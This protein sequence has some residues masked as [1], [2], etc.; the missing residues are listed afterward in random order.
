MKRPSYGVS[1][2]STLV[3]KLTRSASSKRGFYQQQLL[4]RWPLIVG[5]DV[6][7]YCHP[8]KISHDPHGTY[9][10]TLHLR[11][12]PAWAPHVTYM[13]P[14]I[15][16]K[17]ASFLGYRAV[18]RIVI[19]Q[20]PV[21]PAASTAVPLAPAKMRTAPASREAAHALNSI[22]DAEL[23]QRLAA[24]APT[25]TDSAPDAVSQN[26]DSLESDL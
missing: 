16:D 19:H 15:L 26:T 20:A 9:G 14:V 1:A 24:F 12:E 17:I 23:A 10:A 5:R 8:Q 18:S 13:E 11:C 4:T 3:A 7:E 25:A 21:I 6:A 22:A 2:L